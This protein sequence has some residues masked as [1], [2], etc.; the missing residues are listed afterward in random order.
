MVQVLLAAFFL[1]VDAVAVEL[2]TRMPR[3]YGDADWPENGDRVLQGSLIT[4]GNVN[5]T[6]IPG[7]L[8][9]RVVSK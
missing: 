7:A 1:P 6:N 2:Q 5:K 9:S 3:V 8:V 4:L